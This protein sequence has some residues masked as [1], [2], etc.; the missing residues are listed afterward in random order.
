MGIVTGVFE[1]GKMTAGLKHIFIMVFITW[2]IFKFF[3]A[4]V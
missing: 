2:F 3:I 4:G 1:D